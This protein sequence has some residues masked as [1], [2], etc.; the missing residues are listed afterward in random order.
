LSLIPEWFYEGSKLFKSKKHGFPPPRHPGN[1]QAGV[2]SIEKPKEEAKT[3]IP[4]KK[5][6]E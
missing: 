6:R 4:D 1:L 2:H 5:F 3:W